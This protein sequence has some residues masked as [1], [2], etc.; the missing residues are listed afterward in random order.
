VI[1]GG[2]ALP[3]YKSQW[4]FEGFYRFPINDNIT[5]TPA[6]MVITNPY[7]VGDAA[8]APDKGAVIQGVLRATFS[9]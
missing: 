3:N 7:N 2:G 8:Y 9:F 4:N 1:L 6:V 5:L